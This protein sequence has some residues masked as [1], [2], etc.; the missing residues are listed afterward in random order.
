MVK[1]ECTSNA[2]TQVHLSYCLSHETL[3][4]KLVVFHYSVIG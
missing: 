4:S 2:T 3:H 1:N